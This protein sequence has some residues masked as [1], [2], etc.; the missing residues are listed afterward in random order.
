[1]PTEAMCCCQGAAEEKSVSRS[2]S[3]LNTPD[4]AIPFLQS[5][6]GPLLARAEPKAGLKVRAMVPWARVAGAGEPA[7]PWQAELFAEQVLAG[8][9]VPGA[10]S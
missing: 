9:V 2:Q 5:W 8:V 3:Q 10:L 7:K 6:D 1:M 4:F